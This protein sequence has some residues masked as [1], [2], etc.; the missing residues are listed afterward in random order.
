MNHIAKIQALKDEER[1]SN[2]EA[3]FLL[4]KVFSECCTN[5]VGRSR[6]YSFS[7]RDEALDEAV[8]LIGDYDLSTTEYWK[9]EFLEVEDGDPAMDEA[10]AD[11]ARYHRITLG[12]FQIE[13]DDLEN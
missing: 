3:R 10:I 9:S 1:K 6:V 13:I 12:D 2:P 5:A 7:T 8:N 11:L 4:S